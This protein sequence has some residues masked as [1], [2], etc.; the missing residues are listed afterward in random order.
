MPLVIECPSPNFDARPQDQPEG[1]AV[2]IL[3]LHYTGMESATAALARMC[4]ESAKVS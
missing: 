1:Q 3:L 4:D 2:D